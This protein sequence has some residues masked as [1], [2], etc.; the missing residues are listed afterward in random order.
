MG[1]VSTAAGQNGDGTGRTTKVG[2][3]LNKCISV[4]RSVHLASQSRV[5][6]APP[7]PPA[8]KQPSWRV[9]FSTLYPPPSAAA[10]GGG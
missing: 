1:M 7:R 2:T 4:T 8:W 9:F 5:K 3:V 10:D 6:R